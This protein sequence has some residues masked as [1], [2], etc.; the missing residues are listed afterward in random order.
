MQERNDDGLVMVAMETG[1]KWSDSGY[2]LRV[3]LIRFPD[4]LNTDYEKNEHSKMAPNFGED[5]VAIH[6]DL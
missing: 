3:E 1:N 6:C 2:I 4:T 5:E